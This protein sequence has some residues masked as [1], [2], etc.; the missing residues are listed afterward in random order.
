MIRRECFSMNRF[1]PMETMRKNAT[2]NP[3]CGLPI[4]L[5]KFKGRFGY[6]Y[7]KVYDDETIQALVNDG[8]LAETIDPDVLD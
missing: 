1:D 7:R 5:P 2:D 3:S 6:G 8:T 4:E